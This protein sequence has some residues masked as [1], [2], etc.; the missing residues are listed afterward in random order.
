MRVLAYR[1]VMRKRDWVWIVLRWSVSDADRFEEMA[2]AMASASREED[3]TLVY[4]WYLDRETME[5][6]LMEAYPS[7]EALLAHVQGP[8]FT[9]IAPKYRGVGKPA[10]VDVFGGAGLDRNDILR[11]PTAW[12]GEPVAAVTD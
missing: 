1:P 2:D 4:D 5:G 11:A 3:G 7:Q 12:W 9:E 6:V 8:V 10:K